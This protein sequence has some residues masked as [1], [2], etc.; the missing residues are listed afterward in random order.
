L[1]ASPEEEYISPKAV[2]MKTAT[3]SRTISSL[4]VKPIQ[5]FQVTKFVKYVIL[6]HKLVA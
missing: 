5:F 4:T 2:T 1:V 3:M 6:A